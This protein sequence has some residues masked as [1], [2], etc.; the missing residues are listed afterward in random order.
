MIRAGHF[1]GFRRCREARRARRERRRTSWLLNRLFRPVP[2]S[3]PVAAACDV[4]HRQCRE[5]L[6]DGSQVAPLPS[7]C[8][9]GGVNQVVFEQAVVDLVS[10]DD[11]D[12]VADA[13]STLVLLGFGYGFEVST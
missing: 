8:L 2:G 12:V 4:L 3:L 11:F 7:S 6:G 9:E 5:L 10:A 1:S 13:R